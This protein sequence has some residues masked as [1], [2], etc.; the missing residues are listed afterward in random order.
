M[1]IELTHK[2][3]KQVLNCNDP[4]IKSKIYTIIQQ[5]KACDNMDEFPNLKKLVGYKDIFRIRLRSYRIGIVIDNQTVA[6]AAFD[7]RSDI[8]KYFP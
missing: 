5:V 8:Y 7:H 4:R 3:Q 2:F 6:F 1:Q